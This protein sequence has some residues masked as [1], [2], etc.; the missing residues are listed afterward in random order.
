MSTSTVETAQNPAKGTAKNTG[1]A[2]PFPIASRASSRFSYDVGTIAMTAAVKPLSPIQI[3][4]VGYIRRLRMH[5]VFAG[6]AGTGF[7]ADGP[8]NLISQVQLRTSAGSDVYAPMT[9]YQLYQI[10]KYGAFGRVSPYCDPRNPAYYSTTAG[11][12]A[13]FWLDIPFEFDSETGLGVIP[14]MAANR[15]Y[16]LV[17]SLAPYTVVT[18]ATAGTVTITIE[19]DYWTEPPSQ[20]SSGMMQATQPDGLGTLSQWQLETPI[21]SPGDKLTQL[22][23]TGNLTRTLIFTLRTAAGARTDADWPDIC[24]FLLDNDQLFYLPKAT[25]RRMMAEQFAF[26]TA[27]TDVFGGRDVGVYVL[28][29]ASMLGSIAG[30]PANTRSQILPTLDSSLLQLRGTSYGAGASTLEVVSNTIIPTS[31]AVIYNK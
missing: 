20:S 30:D 5:V 24:Q 18:A 9:G 6:T 15:S 11:T 8:F 26:N 19:A 14:A 16:N 3:P 12:A 4:A 28:S 1:M 29:F 13:D 21:V 25:W 31:T 7:T 23:N 10:N 22:H 27:S 17:L 2:L